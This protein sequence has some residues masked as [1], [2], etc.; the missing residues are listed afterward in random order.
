MHSWYKMINLS[1]GWPNNIETA[2]VVYLLQCHQIDIHV[3]GQISYIRLE[4]PPSEI[5]SGDCGI[6][7]AL[8]KNLDLM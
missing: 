5:V 3:F 1:E 4:L 7:V 6:E 2:Q 8:V